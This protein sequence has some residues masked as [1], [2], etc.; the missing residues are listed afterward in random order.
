MIIGITGTLGAGK[1]TVVSYLVKTRGFSHHSAR[2]FLLA[3]I[4]RRGLPTARDNMSMVAN[5]L[6]AKNGASYIIEQ[7]YVQ[8]MAVGGD[9]VIESLH[10]VAG[11][12][13]LKAHGAQVWGV[14]AD[15]K[16]RYER[17]L[18]RESETDH[19]SFEKFVEDNNREIASDDP[20]KHNIRK[21]IEMAD[22]KLT[23]DG[24]PEE[25]FAQVEAALQKISQ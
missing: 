3:E 16:T 1:G 10:E 9:A 19:V 25:L 5:D 2:T 15:I 12:E 4:A 21:V 6:R 20:K 24:T 17:I 8:A 13:F 7:L 18:K 14:D 23:N 11:A 22:I